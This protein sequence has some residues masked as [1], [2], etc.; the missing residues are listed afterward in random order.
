M[1]RH[2]L[3]AGAVVTG[4]FVAFS[5][6]VVRTRDPARASG[7]LRPEDT[8]QGHL[9]ALSFTESEDLLGKLRAQ[10]AAAKDPQRRAVLSAELS[11]LL[12][13]EHKHALAL[14][15]LKDALR[16]FPD[17]PELLARAALLHHVLG[18]QAQ[19]AAEISAAVHQAPDLPLVRN[20]AAI[21]EGRT[22][23]NP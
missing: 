13:L 14:A 16:A 12:V 17:R 3:V 18:Q 2:D 15:E 6:A 19:A 1:K 8:R 23:T 21:I 20:A 5:L 22:A 9:G 7:V 4:L 11:D 10:R